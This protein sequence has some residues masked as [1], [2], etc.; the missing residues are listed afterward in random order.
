[1]PYLKAC[2]GSNT[3]ETHAAVAEELGISLGRLSLLKLAAAHIGVDRVPE[4][5]DQQLDAEFEFFKELN[6]A[7]I[8]GLEVVVT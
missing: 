7:A 1:M 6:E 8:T 2:H 3:R 5:P 4:L